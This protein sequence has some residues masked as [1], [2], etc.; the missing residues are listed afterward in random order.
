M[1]IRKKQPIGIELVKKGIVSSDSIEKALNYQLEHPNKRIGDILYILEE[2]DPDVLIKNIGEI[3]GQKGIFLTVD[4]ISIQEDEYIPLDSMKRYKAIPFEIE[5]GKIK[6]AFADVENNKSNMK[7]IRMLMLNK[8]LVMEPYVALETNIDELLARFDKKKTEDI[9]NLKD[10][11]NVTELVDNIIRLAIEKR[12]S[13]IHIEPQL[14][15]V[16]VRYRIDGELFVMAKIRKRKTI[17]NYRK[18][19]SNIKYAPGKARISRW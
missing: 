4:K 16:R 5:A 10:T 2:A 14:D 1:E 8:G 18:T 7:D 9:E 3:I 17:T 15:E 13:D 11:E 19:K 12:A 6:V